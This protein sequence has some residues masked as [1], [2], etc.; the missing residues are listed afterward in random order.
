MMECVHVE[1]MQ[2]EFEGMLLEVGVAFLLREG[3]IIW[4]RSVKNKIEEIR[5]LQNENGSVTRVQSQGVC[6][7]QR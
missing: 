1:N 5:T 3:C 4:K 7:V 6:Q 2:V